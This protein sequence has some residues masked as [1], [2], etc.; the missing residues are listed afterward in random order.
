MSLLSSPA[1][2]GISDVYSTLDPTSDSSS[3]PRWVALENGVATAKEYALLWVSVPS[4]FGVFQCYLRFSIRADRGACI[5]G[6]DWFNIFREY[7]IAQESHT[8]E[9]TV[10]GLSGRSFCPEACFWIW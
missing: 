1:V 7:V 8:H 4:D 2:I 9:E 3:L 10:Q 6:K 5:L